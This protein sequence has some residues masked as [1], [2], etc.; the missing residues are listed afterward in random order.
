MSATA[1]WHLSHLDTRSQFAKPGLKKLIKSTFSRAQ[2]RGAKRDVARE[3]TLALA[4]DLSS[5]TPDELELYAD[6]LLQ[7]SH[8]DDVQP[9]GDS[10][11]PE[12]EQS[13]IA[14]EPSIPC[15]LQGALPDWMLAQMEAAK[16]SAFELLSLFES[17]GNPSP[18]AAISM[19]DEALYA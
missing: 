4:T 2:R 18:K 10:H 7:A 16:G 3:T 6:A 11:W 19:D 5:M 15:N 12:E 14:E 8:L 9:D 17:K 13:F 1:Y